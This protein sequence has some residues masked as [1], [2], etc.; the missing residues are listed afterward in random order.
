MKSL[1]I[2]FSSPAHP[3][4]SVAQQKHLPAKET[5]SARVV[6]ESRPSDAHVEQHWDQYSPP[7]SNGLSASFLVLM[8]RPNDTK[9][10]VASANEIRPVWPR[11]VVVVAD[12]RRFSRTRDHP[13]HLEFG[14]VVHGLSVP[15]RVGT[16]LSDVLESG[17]RI[18]PVPLDPILSATPSRKTTLVDSHDT[19][20]S[21]A[22][23][24]T[25]C[26]VASTASTLCLVSGFY[27]L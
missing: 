27:R 13:V 11:L 22:L 19:L 20:L 2:S 16:K 6:V 1:R 9:Y 10:R 5:S 3:N 23:L 12:R 17:H 15:A 18:F 25:L 24:A 7:V 14:V 8:K 26:L 21:S 4:F